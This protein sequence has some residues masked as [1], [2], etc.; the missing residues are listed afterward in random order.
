MLRISKL[1]SRYPF[2]NAEGSSAPETVDVEASQLKLQLQC[3]SDLIAS[4]QQIPAFRVCVAGRHVL[5]TRERS[6]DRA[7]FQ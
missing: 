4:G 3:L 7:R 6:D 2:Y 1:G 5:F